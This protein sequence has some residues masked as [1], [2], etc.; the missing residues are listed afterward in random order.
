MFA[1][2]TQE[3]YVQDY[4]SIDWPKQRNNV[5]FADLYSPHSKVLD[6]LNS[7]MA[8]YEKL[9]NSWIR[10]ASLALALEQ[11][12]AE[13]SNTDFLC[14]GPVNKVMNVL[15]V[16][17]VDG[18]DS[19]TFKRHIERIPDFMWMSSEGMMMNGTNGSQLWDTAFIAQAAM[20]S[21]LANEKEFWPLMEKI[22]QFMD[23]MQMK[24]NVP[25]HDKFNRHIS[26]GAWP[27]STRDQGYT[28]SDCTAEGLKTVLSIQS[29]LSYCRPLISKQRLCDAVDVL[30]S[31]QNSDGGFAS[32]EKIR[33][34]EWLEWLNPA[35]VFGKIM[36]EYSYPECS[37]AVLLGLTSFRKQYPD[38]RTSEIDTA[39]LRAAEF[40]RNSQKTD[41][42]WYG[43]W[44]ICFTYATLFAVESLSSVGETYENSVILQKACQFLVS[45][46]MDD[47][48][49][50]ETYK[51]CELGVY[52]NHER[53][54]VVQTAWAVL[55]LMAC[56]YPNKDIITR[57]IKLIMSRQQSN[58][59][60]PQES[61][62]GVFNKN[63]MISYPNYK[64]AFTI[65][66]LG[67]Y[68]M[69][70]K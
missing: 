12:R 7:I 70:Y 5:C 44:G 37:T 63:C 11:V 25:N 4:D 13:D 57:G 42:S 68:S 51:S 6:L 23:D 54:Q 40:V 28:V 35:E 50:G 2:L 34:P 32:Y 53:S 33:G 36:I 14:L 48:G 66:A 24:K 21:G 43:A 26:K 1:G 22:N 58:G 45:K 64:F 15:V 59:E 3:L 60:W 61:I 20:E 62:E 56:K 47:G 69:I 16:W 65:W 27:F 8:I 39:V 30:L 31:M 38:Y 55:S 18:P 29:K 49:W 9:P 10:N 19:E 67:R 46:Q 17:L 52:V 41:G